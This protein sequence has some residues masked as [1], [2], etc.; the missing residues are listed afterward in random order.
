VRRALTTALVILAGCA[1]SPS[2]Q[3]TEAPN[4]TTT[5]E[6]RVEGTTLV[7]G[8]YWADIAAVSGTRTVVFHVMRVRFGEDC[9]RWAAENGY[10][11]ACMNDYEVEQWPD[12]YAALAGD[13]VVSVAEPTGP[14]MNYRIDADTLHRLV[15]KETTGPD[16]YQ[17]T[18]FPFVVRIEDGSVVSADQFWVP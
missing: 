10:E 7:D 2:W 5:D 18:P 1:D 16:G 13:A 14:G 4:V 12:A 3:R 6:V 9:L 15:F 17:W 8:T 11:D